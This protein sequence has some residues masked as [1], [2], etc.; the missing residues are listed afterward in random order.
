MR[1]YERVI[2]ACCF[3]FIFVNVGM[4]SSS[5]SVYQP[6]ITALPGVG[7]AGGAAVL[8]VRT[9]CSFLAMFAVNAYL[10]RLGVRYGAALACCLT[11]AGFL[12]YSVA[13]TTRVFFLGAVLMGVG[14]GLGGMVGMTMLVSRWFSTRVGTAVGVASAGSGA[15]AV[16]VPLVAVRL[17]HGVSLACAFAVEGA[18][19]I[20]VGLLVLVFLRDTPAQAGCTPFGHESVRSQ[21]ERPPAGQGA[22]AFDAAAGSGDDGSAGADGGREALPRHAYALLFAAMAVVGAFCVGGTGYVS[23]NL[24][25]AGFGYTFAATMVSVAGF[26][27]AVAKFAGGVLID[28][29]GPRTGTTLL[30]S[31]LLAGT[32]CFALAGLGSHVLSCAGAV[33]YG[34]GACVGSVGISLWGLDLST[35]ATRARDVRNFQICYNLGSFL[36]NMLPGVIVGTFGTYTVVYGILFACGVYAACVIVWAY[37]R[38]RRF[39]G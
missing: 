6:Y 10:R 1:H 20:V 11:G 8:A 33:L 2:V 30:F 37:A 38:Y 17:I 14:Y 31:M 28:R 15:A 29:V 22:D 18:C 7:A 12:V 13:Q 27:L 36:F 34:A 39:L 9:L 23:V 4:P 21:T 3:A 25:T 32:A 35:P 24:T 5:I 19:A 26:A 16:F